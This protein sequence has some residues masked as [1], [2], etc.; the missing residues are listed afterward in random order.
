MHPIEVII[1]QGPLQAFFALEAPYSWVECRTDM[2]QHFNMRQED[3]CCKEMSKYPN[4]KMPSRF[5]VLTLKKLKKHLFDS[6]R[7]RKQSQNGILTNSKECLI[8]RSSTCV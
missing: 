1:S 4:I 3:G 8:I 6:F 5:D 2:L 7:C